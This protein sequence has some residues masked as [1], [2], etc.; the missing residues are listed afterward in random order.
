MCCHRIQQIKLL[1]I[2]GSGKNKKLFITS[3]HD[4][5]AAMVKTSKVLKVAN[6][7]HCTN[8]ALHLLLTSDSVNKLDEVTE[9]VQK[10][11]NIVTAFHFKTIV[12]EDEMAATLDKKLIAELQEK[13]SDVSDLLDMDDQYSVG[14]DEDE[15]DDTE[16]AE[17]SQMA[18]SKPAVHCH[19]SLKAACPTR[20]NSMLHMVESVMQ[21]KL[22]VENALKRCGRVDLC[23]SDDELEFLAEFVE[24][25]KPFKTFT[26][27]FT[28]SMPT[29]SVVP[30]VK[31]KII[32]NIIMVYFV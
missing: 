27:L 19:A 7:Q 6:F 15:S 30:L 20:W 29:L 28:C 11:R 10:C 16:T 1:I 17:S 9:I 18:T 23:L 25:L 32:Y 26:D 4:G 24:F 2:L 3:C 22:E 5:A 12:M 31:G 13:M 21:L 14:L 8:H